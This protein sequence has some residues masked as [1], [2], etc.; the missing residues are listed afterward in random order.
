MSL[1]VLQINTK[2]S[3]RS[4]WFIQLVFWSL[5]F[6]YKIQVEYR[7]VYDMYAHIDKVAVFSFLYMF[8]YSYTGMLLSSTVPYVYKNWLI[9]TESIVRFI[10][11]LVLYAFVLAN[12]WLAE[13]L[14]LDRILLNFGFDIS[15]VTFKYYSWEIFQGIFIFLC[16]SLIYTTIQQNVNRLS[17]ETKLVNVTLMA[18]RAQLQ[19]LKYQLNPHFLFNILNSIHSFAQRDADKTAFVIM[20]LSDMMRYMIY[21]AKEEKV[22][23][24]KE[25]AYLQSFIELHKVRFAHSDFVNFIVK[26]NTNQVFLPPLLFIPFIEN[27]FKYGSKQVG[28]TIDIVLELSNNE[29]E[30]TCGNKKRELSETEIKNQGGLGIENARQRLSLLF[31]GKHTLDIKNDSSEY[32]VTLKINLT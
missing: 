15:E 28:D 24:D 17:N 29:L 14:L 9:Q 30:F 6:I 19:L 4:F 7:W 5:F 12:F 32:V 11:L 31:G 2:N 18:E 3:K 25:I 1:K 21:E 22:S 26:G 16:W 20:K 13:V 10:S 23:L 8:V 27:A